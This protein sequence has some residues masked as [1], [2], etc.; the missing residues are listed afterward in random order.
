MKVI[1]RI[2]KQC[3]RGL[4]PRYENM[5]LSIVRSNRLATFR[6][7]GNH[8]GVG[9]AIR[10]QSQEQTPNFAG[11]CVVRKRMSCLGLIGL[12]IALAKEP[13]PLRVWGFSFGLTAVSVGRINTGADNQ[14]A[15][16]GDSS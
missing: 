5:Q 11:M 15:N 7:L 9:K 6:N 3:S 12:Q 14:S 4:F 13:H 2:E 1:I 16:R 10:N 8:S